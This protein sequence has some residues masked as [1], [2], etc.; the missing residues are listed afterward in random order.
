MDNGKNLVFQ[1][2]EIELVEMTLIKKNNQL[3]LLWKIVIKGSLILITF[4]NV[5]RFRIGELSMPLVIHGLEII[6]HSKDAWEK[7]ST[8]EIRDF[9]N[10]CV[11]LFCERFEING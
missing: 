6:N 2:N 10:D 1:G 11:H 3:E 9:E 4:H 5:S 7:D 8:Y